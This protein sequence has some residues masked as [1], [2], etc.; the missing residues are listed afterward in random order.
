MIKYICIKEIP[1]YNSLK[2][3]DIV[4]CDNINFNFNKLKTKNGTIFLYD[5]EIK[6]NLISIE[7][8]RNKRLVKILEHE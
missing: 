7:E 6:E 8:F 4:I 3:Y 2:L 1:N 5:N